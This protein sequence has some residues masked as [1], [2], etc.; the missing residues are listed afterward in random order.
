M[1][2][3]L[4]TLHCTEVNIRE[5]FHVTLHRIVRSSYAEPNVARWNSFG[6]RVAS[7]DGTAGPAGQ[8][9]TKIHDD[10]HQGAAGNRPRRPEPGSLQDLLQAANDALQCLDGGDFSG[11]RVNLQSLID[12]LAEQIE[13]PGGKA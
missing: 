7:F 8:L 4:S 9:S 6:W 13:R 10:P 12:E 11:C 2:A 5:V 3:K 1:I